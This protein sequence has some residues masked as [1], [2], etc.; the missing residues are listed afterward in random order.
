MVLPIFQVT[1]GNIRRQISR[2][3]GDLWAT[4]GS[5]ASPSTNGFVSPMLVFGN[6]ADI[7]GA[8]VSFFS[9]GGASIAENPR[10]ISGASPG[11]VSAS[12]DLRVIPVW[13]P[14]PSTNS[15]WEVHRKFSRLQYD[16][17]IT[18]SIRRVARRV[19]LPA[20]ELFILNSW[21]RNPMFGVWSN[22]Y[23]SVPDYWTLTGAGS[24]VARTTVSVVRGIEIARLSVALDTATYM[25]GEIVDTSSLI[26][27]TISLSVLCATAFANRAR[28]IL[29]GSVDGVIAQSGFHAGVS[30]GDGVGLWRELTINNVAIPTTGQ[31]LAVRLNVASGAAINV[32]WTQVRVDGGSRW[33]Y[34]MAERFAYIQDLYVSSEEGRWELVPKE[35][36]YINRGYAIN[37]VSGDDAGRG[38]LGILRQFW[39]PTTGEILKAVGQRYVRDPGEEDN[40]PVDPE[41]V[42]S[43]AAADL[44]LLLPRGSADWKGYSEQAREWERKAQEME[45]RVFVRPYQGSKAVV[46]V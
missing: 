35:W 44:Y 42:F 14:A 1:K 46:E 31:T 28:L 17:A 33:T 12:G 10:T 45:R 9:G 32:N 4:S 19:L 26:G 24:S 3:F 20:E 25:E 40:L 29:Q 34:P 13:S 21:I 16:D 7:R 2:A 43:R 27:Q 37:T 11:S 18:R 6:A 39:S 30:G 15:G 41:Y 36:W 23:S 5:L 8:E 38:M 22:G